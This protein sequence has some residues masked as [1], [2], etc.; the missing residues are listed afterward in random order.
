[1]LIVCASIYGSSA[2][3]AYGSLG[4][5]KAMFLS[6]WLVCSLKQFY[7]MKNCSLLESACQER[8]SILSKNKL[9]VIIQPPGAGG[10]SKVGCNKPAPIS[11]L[12]LTHR[13]TGHDLHAILRSHSIIG[14]E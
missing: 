13:Y 2:S 6:L 1:M 11:F 7:I 5:S 3:T 9:T 4:N 14:S 8:Y 12:I 10:W